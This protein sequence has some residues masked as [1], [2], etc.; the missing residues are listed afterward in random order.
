MQRIGLLGGLSWVST[1]EYYRRLNELVQAQLGGTASARIILESPNHQAYVDAVIQRQD[2]EAA[3][4]QRKR[5]SMS[6]T[7]TPRLYGKTRGWVRL[8]W[9]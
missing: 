6:H 4:S 1:A 3:Y 5:P 9:M 7:R 2:E 8:G